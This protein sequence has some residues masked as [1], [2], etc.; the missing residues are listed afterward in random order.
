ML[1]KI[2]GR[3]RRGHQRMRR[4][5]GITDA[6]DMN[7]GKLWE[8]VRDREAWR[9]AVHGVAKNRT[10]LAVWTTTTTT[11]TTP[12]TQVKDDG[13]LDQ[14]GQWGRWKGSDCWGW[15]G[16]SGGRE[17]IKKC[18]KEEGWEGRRMK[19]RKEV[20]TVVIIHQYAVIYWST[21]APWFIAYLYQLATVIIM[22]HNKLPWNSVA[23]TTIIYS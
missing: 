2:K 23:K 19:G 10:W 20:L 12:M 22:L 5:N 15:E 21:L 1:G 16:C 8:M 13:T 14:P 17:E 9:A 3:R 11:T 6:M 4:L 18:R 7:L